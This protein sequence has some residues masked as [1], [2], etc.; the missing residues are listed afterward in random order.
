MAPLQKRAWISLSIGVVWFPAWLT[1][2]LSRGSGFT[3]FFQ[4]RLWQGNW[5]F[6]VIFFLGLIALIAVQLVYRGKR[7]QAGVNA[8]ER[9]IFIM[10]RAKVVAAFVTFI[11]VL[12]AWLIPWSI[13]AG[14][15]G[16]TVPID[17]LPFI[18][19]SQ[20]IVFFMAEALATIILYR[21]R[22]GYAEG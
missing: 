16:D 20:A 15:G 9:D 4:E 13:Y 17:L 10:K 3:G 12:L 5:A 19:L 14:Q 11:T 18:G 2:V 7:G 21:L 6:F 8:D 1:L 22:L